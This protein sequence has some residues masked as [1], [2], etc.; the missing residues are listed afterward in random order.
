[1]IGGM[2]HGAGVQDDEERQKRAMAG[3][4]TRW[5]MRWVRVKPQGAPCRWGFAG[6]RVVTMVACPAWSPTLRCTGSDRGP[7]VRHEPLIG[8]SGHMPI[9]VWAADH[10]PILVGASGRMPHPC[11]AGRSVLNAVLS[12]PGWRI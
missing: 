12:W 6:L 8:A 4:L 7:I 9:R 3:A 10:M 1:M 11:H 2:S 5:G